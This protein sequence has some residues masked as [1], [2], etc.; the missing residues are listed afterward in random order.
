MKKTEHG[1]TLFELII[2]VAIIGVL[3]GIATPLYIGYIKDGKV[4]KAAADIAKISMDCARFKS[5]YGIYPGSL[6]DV[7]ADQILDPWN[8]PY[9]YFRIEGSLE[10]GMM[11]KDRFMVPINSDFDLYSKGAD[12]KSLTPLQA[13]DSKDDVIRANDGGYIGLAEGY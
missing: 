3:S 8:K 1:F 5:D 6:A 7:H 2:T 11:R 12:G 9:Q 13:K 10:T 4:A